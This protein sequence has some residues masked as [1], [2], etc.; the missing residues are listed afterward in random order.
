MLTAFW[1]RTRER[2]VEEDALLKR[3]KAMLSALRRR[4]K[5]EGDC[6]RMQSAVVIAPAELVEMRAGRLRRRQNVVYKCKCDN[7]LF[8]S[9]S[10]LDVGAAG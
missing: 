8:V 6:I 10:L 9:F 5:I 2:G 3:A 7:I 1:R 4:V